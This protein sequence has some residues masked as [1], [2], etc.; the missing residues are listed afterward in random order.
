[1]AKDPQRRDMILQA[2]QESRLEAL[3]SLFPAEVLLL[4]GCW[5]VMGTSVAFCTRK[6]ELCAIVPE[7]ELELAKATSDAEF[8]TYRPGTLDRF[9]PFTEALVGPI[10]SL[11]SPLRLKSEEIGIDLGSG[12]QGSSYPSVNHF[13]F[14]VFSLLNASAPE[15]T[16]ISVDV[17][18]E[19]LKAVKTASE[20]DILPRVCQRAAIG[21][22][23]ADDAILNPATSLRPA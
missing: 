22:R 20:V 3:D 12:A 8:F 7:D 13:R 21:F 9:V 14:S 19:S 11:V 1:M 6:G 17:F 18:F 23:D 5:P 4:T 2:L 16:A 10:K 15:M